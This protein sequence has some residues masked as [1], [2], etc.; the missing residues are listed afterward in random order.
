M[1]TFNCYC[2]LYLR[3]ASAY[4]RKRNCCVHPTI[5]GEKMFYIRRR[6]VVGFERRRNGNSS[7]GASGVETYAK[8]SPDGKWIA[9]QDNMTV[10]NRLCNA[11]NR[12]RTETVD[13]LFFARTARAA[14]GI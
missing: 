2:W 3:F 13:I 14:L 1:I 10:M 5:D 4:R 8:F 7:D 11:G 9:S 6:F 12:R